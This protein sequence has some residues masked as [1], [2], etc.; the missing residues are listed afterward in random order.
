MSYQTCENCHKNVAT[1]TV[2]EILPKA[3]GE[4]ESAHHQQ[5]LCEMCAQSKNLPHAPVVKKTL[6]DIWKLLQSSGNQGKE[7]PDIECPECGMTREELRTRGRIG[8]A[9]DYELFASDIEEIL[10]RVHG[11]LQHD[12]RIPGISSDELDRMQV[13]SSLK[14]EL[15]EAIREEAYENAARI[16]DELQSL[17][18]GA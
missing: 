1:V 2:I 18:E 16:R 5:L 8:C 10:E 17:G 7:E 14:K 15:N 11:A 13:I 3:D 12:G 4:V 9:N 6:G